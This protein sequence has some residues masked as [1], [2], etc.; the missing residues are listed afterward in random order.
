MLTGIWTGIV[1]E[2]TA[3]IGTATVNLVQ[4]GST[5]EGTYEL[6]APGGGTGRVTGTVIDRTLVMF[7]TPEVGITCANGAS[8]SGTLN[9]QLTLTDGRATGTYTTF[10][11]D[12]PV[13]RAIELSKQ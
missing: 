6:A 8:L 9:V 1:K 5:V 2:A 10:N 13:Q 4:S 3:V 7:L 12:M 11:C